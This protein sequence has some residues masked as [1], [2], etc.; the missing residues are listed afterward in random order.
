MKL[1][2]TPNQ[3]RILMRSLDD[4]MDDDS[5]DIKDCETAGRISFLLKQGLTKKGS[6]K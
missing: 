4:F 5:N 3:A 1:D 6:K 2:L